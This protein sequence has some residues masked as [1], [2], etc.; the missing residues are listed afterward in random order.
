[1]DSLIIKLV[2]FLKLFDLARIA[3]TLAKKRSK[4]CDLWKLALSPPKSGKCIKKTS[5]P[6]FWGYVGF[7]KWTPFFS[8]GVGSAIV[9][10]MKTG[11]LGKYRD[12]HNPTLFPII[13]FKYLSKD[14]TIFSQKQAFSPVFWWNLSHFLALKSN[15]STFLIL[16]QQCHNLEVKLIQ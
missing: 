8:F 2:C 9:W 1:M 10:H 15:M 6:L 13:I 12:D 5:I 11:T 4:M 7:K 14:Y 3:V 16:W